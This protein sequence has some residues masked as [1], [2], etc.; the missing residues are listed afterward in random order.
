MISLALPLPSL[1]PRVFASRIRRSCL[2]FAMHDVARDLEEPF[3]SELGIYL[4]AN[5]LQVPFM[6]AEFDDRLLACNGAAVRPLLVMQPPEADADLDMHEEALFG[7]MV[8]DAL[9]HFVESPMR[10]PRKTVSS[11]R[12]EGGT[13]SRASG[14][15]SSPKSIRKSERKSSGANG[16]AED[17]SPPKPSS[18]AARFRLS[19]SA[20]TWEDDGGS[21]SPVSGKVE[22]SNVTVSVKP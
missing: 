8:D 6:Q 20:V 10:S 11:E 18:S 12:S 16:A 2:L 5:R 14:R 4:G 21:A 13:S 19:G 3:T 22:V 17:S 9:G 1:P 7:D 15:C